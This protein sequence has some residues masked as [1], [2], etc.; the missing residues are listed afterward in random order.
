MA[1]NDPIIII[2]T[3]P[4]RPGGLAAEG[5][6]DARESGSDYAQ[7]HALIDE[8]EQTGARVIIR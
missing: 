8:A 7:A 2:I 1:Q 5:E 3:P 6:V 4:P